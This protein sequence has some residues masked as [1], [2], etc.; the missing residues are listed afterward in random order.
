LFV[1]G[2]LFFVIVS[3]FVV[4]GP[5]F[6]LP[7]P[8]TVCQDSQSSFS[9]VSLLSSACEKSAAWVG[10]LFGVAV[11]YVLILYV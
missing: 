8:L 1:F 3:T 9:L 6:F 5:V 2:G 7:L 11:W 10:A 4:L